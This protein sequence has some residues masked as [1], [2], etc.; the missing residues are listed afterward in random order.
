MLEESVKADFHR[1][2][3]KFRFLDLTESAVARLQTCLPN[4]DLRV[5]CRNTGA[6]VTFIITERL[7]TEALCSFLNSESLDPKKYSVWV[8]VVSS[9]DHD[10]VA[11]PKYV[12][13]IIRRTECG[14]DFSFVGCLGDP[15]EDEHNSS[16]TPGTVP[17]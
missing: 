9:S 2:R 10:G 8:S 11:L 5:N 3:F 15:V 14:V 16:V 6:V 4:T 1:E 13:D 7:D 12:L 17:N